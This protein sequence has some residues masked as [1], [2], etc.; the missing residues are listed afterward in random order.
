MHFYSN[1]D[2]KVIQKIFSPN[3][4]C[5]SRRK[6]LKLR[7][8]PLHLSAQVPSSGK[9]IV[10]TG[11][12]AG[13]GK[14]RTNSKNVSDYEKRDAEPPCGR[15]GKKTHDRR[16]QPRV[17]RKDDKRIGRGEV[18]RERRKYA[19]AS[20]QALR[21]RQILD[22]HRVS[23]D[24][25][26]RQG[27]NDKTCHER[28]QSTGLPGVFVQA[29]LIRGVGAR[30]PVEDIQEPARKGTHRRFQPF[31]LRRG[32]RNQSASRDTSQRAFDRH[33]EGGRDRRRIPG[34]TLPT[35]QRFRALSYREMGWW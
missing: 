22:P 20:K 11:E 7:S 35:N 15:A 26:R 31:A 5:L 29:A 34:D 12:G 3:F 13:A 6:R 30:I 23:G 14:S 24:G 19:G 32:H 9:D 25:C 16:F 4:F 27:R 8:H 10:R 28:H 17:H 21:P 33:R 18:E 2:A 1:A